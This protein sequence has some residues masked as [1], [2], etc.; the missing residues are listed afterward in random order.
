MGAAARIPYKLGSIITW[1]SNYPQSLLLAQLPLFSWLIL[2]D[3]PQTKSPSPEKKGKKK[4]NW[5]TF[6]LSNAFWQLSISR[7][8]LPQKCASQDPEPQAFPCLLDPL[9]LQIWVGI[10]PLAHTLPAWFLLT[11]WLAS[12]APLSSYHPPHHTPLSLFVNTRTRVLL[13]EGFF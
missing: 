5:Q 11:F 1:T 8:P 9:S 7:H 10:C 4:T 13:Q 2:P 3:T 6:C 12:A